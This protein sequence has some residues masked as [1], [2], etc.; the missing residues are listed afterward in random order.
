MLTLL[1]HNDFHIFIQPS[2]SR[3]GT[4]AACNSAYD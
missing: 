4:G 2:Q 1:K 3:S